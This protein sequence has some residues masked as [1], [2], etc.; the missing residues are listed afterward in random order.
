MGC[1]SRSHQLSPHQR[2]HLTPVHHRC[3]NQQRDSYQ[4]P[5]SR[6]STSITPR[7]HLS[8]PDNTSDLN[9]RQPGYVMLTNWLAGGENRLPLFPHH[10]VQ[11][12][13]AN[14]VMTIIDN[15]QVGAAGM[16]LGEVG[17]VLHVL[18]IREASGDIAC[19][20]EREERCLFE[21]EQTWR[22]A[23][24]VHRGENYTVYVHHGHIVRRDSEDAGLLEAPW[25]YY[26]GILLLVSHLNCCCY[27]TAPRFTAAPARV[28]I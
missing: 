13:A 12:A 28:P 18:A 21:L 16:V 20:C 2:D 4:R 17:G 25:R 6:D 11:H 9:H 24:C 22:C 1:G 23:V 27:T 5:Q 8:S 26:N 10:Q 14:H 3:P 7:H 15:G 19:V